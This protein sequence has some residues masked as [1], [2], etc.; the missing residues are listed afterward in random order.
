MFSDEKKPMT[1]KS[2]RIV[3]G[4]FIERVAKRTR[5]AQPIG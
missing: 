2:L 1:Q 5:L 3:I 4:S